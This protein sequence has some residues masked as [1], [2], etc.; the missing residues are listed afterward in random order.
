ML[1][2][3]FSNLCQKRLG[4]SVTGNSDVINV[5]SHS[6]ALLCRQIRD[7]VKHLPCSEKGNA[8]TYSTT[9]RQVNLAIT[10]DI[11]QVSCHI[12]GTLKILKE[13]PVHHRPK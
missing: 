8:A 10:A 4:C 1:T 9:G 11:S 13:H 12:I 5:G 7:A 6:A 2:H 3:D